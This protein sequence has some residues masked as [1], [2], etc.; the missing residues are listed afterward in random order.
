MFNDLVIN[1]PF[2]GLRAFE[3]H[4]DVLFFGREKQVDELLKK[5]RTTRFL[6]VIGS[7]GS[8]KSSLIKSGLIPALHSG[9]M[10]GAGSQWRICSFRPG[11]DPIHNMAVGLSQPGVLY[12]QSEDHDT[13]IT[14]AINESILRRSSTGLIGAY[15]QS[16]IDTRQN[17]LV[18]VDQFEELF[19][20]SKYE[21]DAKDGKRDSVAFINLL[22]KATEQREVPIYVVFTMRSDFLGD[23]T[24][25]RGLPEAINDGDYLVP[26]MTREER[27]EAIVAPIS[28]AG[29][30]ISP[31]LLNQLLNDVGDNPDQLPILQHA[32][33]R[34][35]DTWKQKDQPDSPIDIT[36]YEEIG[37]MQYAL[38][39]HAEEAY[40]E[41]ATERQRYICEVLF[42]ALTDKGSDARGIRRP[43]KLGEICALA[44]AK[45]DEVVEVINV[46]RRG[47]RAFL[48]PP[49]KVTLTESSIIDISHE[50]I[51]RVWERLMN[52]VDEE[53]ES[54]QVY[55]RL[56]EAAALYEAGRGGLWRDPELQVTW[57]WKEE[58]Q[59]NLTWAS[60]YNDQFEKAMLFLE[61]SKKQFELEM[62]HKEEMQKLRLRR[63]RRVAITVSV[64]AVLALFLSIYAFQLKNIATRQTELAVKKTAE[65][66]QSQKVAVEQR[67]IADASK[68]EALEGKLQAEQSKEVAVKQKEIADA[69]KIKA[70]Q[71]RQ[72]ALIQ[73][74]LA[75]EQ[76]RYAER[77]KI[78][79]EA[80]EKAAREQ[81]TIAEQQTAKA[82]ESEKVTA[83]EKRKSTRL[84]DLAE[85]R[86][87]AYE[88]LLLLNEKKIDE[89]RAKASEA[90][91]LNLANNGPIQNSDIFNALQYNWE[92]NIQFRN[93][94]L[95]HKSPVRAIAG[96]PKSNIVFSADEEGALYVSAVDENGWQPV[97]VFQLKEPVRSLAASPDGNKLVALTSAGNGVLF[98]VSADNA[99][100]VAGRFHINGISRNILFNGTDA[101]IV[102]SSSG[103]TRYKTNPSLTED[104]VFR[105]SDLAAAATGKSG[106]IYLASGNTLNVF[107]K[108]ESLGDKPA[109]S[110][111]LGGRIVSI[112]TDNNEQYLAAGTYE[113]AVWLKDMR[114]NGTAVNLPLHLS[115][116]NDLR[117]A[118]V[119]NGRLQLAS[120][121]ADQS[122]KLIDVRSAT[123]DKNT[124]DVI[125]LKGHSK[126]IYGLTYLPGG[127]MIVSSSEDNKVIAW[128][129]VMSD[130]Y[131]SLNKK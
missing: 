122:I 91:K 97:S 131:Q 92:N 69:A 118:Q 26:R 83:E 90:Y 104:G 70:E 55:F 79:A 119:S 5:L 22:L 121:S 34:T 112:A 42:K 45:L 18:L 86:N 44:E 117:F 63:A 4:E 111:R 31:R 96:R 48:M 101:F 100:S 25:F 77:Q 29:A 53:N 71:S 72:E 115:S 32:L 114:S 110:Y 105:I 78:V 66:E 60:R 76:K 120:G 129:P 41:L 14:T 106:R 54:A 68:E 62:K 13:E 16:G 64:V 12:E 99:L 113:G 38:M 36:D 107:D 81:K 21:K 93:Q 109:A 103:L 33:M 35:W 128:K 95:L 19:R 37:G 75:E 98:N 102:V 61:H 28:V 46:F 43:R 124:E 88:S 56:C 3:E 58:Q 59:P 51:M 52:W 125:T 17:L 27:K 50:S 49:E 82:V 40:A 1:N 6:A 130:L 8:G 7:S 127:E 9:F 15:R 65:A 39:Q 47:G 126:W 10:S 87:L 116:V 73:K 89:S 24:E 30:N 67:K 23:C 123:G 20:F 2:P 80:N 94:F 85:S 11:N 57:K 74:N 108:W 84:K